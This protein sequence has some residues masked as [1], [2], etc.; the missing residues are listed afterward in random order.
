MHYVTFIGIS[1]DS[2]CFVFIQVMQ[3]RRREDGHQNISGISKMS[4]LIIICCW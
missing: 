3:R 1:F 2:N 4:A